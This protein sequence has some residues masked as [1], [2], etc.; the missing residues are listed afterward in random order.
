MQTAFIKTLSTIKEI[1]AKLK[2]TGQEFTAQHMRRD[3]IGWYVKTKLLNEQYHSQGG[4]SREDLTK[5]K[6]EFDDFCELINDYNIK[7]GKD[8]KDTSDSVK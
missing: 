7:I 4:G 8:G 3:L 6:K 1:E 5:A 2:K